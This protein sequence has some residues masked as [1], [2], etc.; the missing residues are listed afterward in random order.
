M[1]ALAAVAECP[2]K[3]AA[4]YAFATSTGAKLVEARQENTGRWSHYEH[5]AFLLALQIYEREWK[6][7]A[8]VVRTRTVMQTRTYAQ[9]FFIS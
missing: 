7:V 5:E 6:K 3:A 2:T 9:K 1:N 8:S 4:V